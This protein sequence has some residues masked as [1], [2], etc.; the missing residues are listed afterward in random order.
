MW[1]HRAVAPCNDFRYRICLSNKM[2]G[3]DWT[4]A[5]DAKMQ[6]GRGVSGIPGVPHSPYLL[7]GP[8][9]IINLNWPPRSNSGCNRKEYNASRLD[10]NSRRRISSSPVATCVLR[11]AVSPVSLKR[12]AI[13]PSTL[14]PRLTK[15]RYPP[16]SALLGSQKNAIPVHEFQLA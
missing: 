16:A 4:I 2:K 9:L 5:V 7:S 1:N 12:S 14:T 15:N 13:S 6:V 11:M 10:S 8:Y 3:I